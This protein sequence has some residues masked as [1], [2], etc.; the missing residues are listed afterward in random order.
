[1]TTQTTASQLSLA[2][3]Q[4]G[5]PTPSPHFLTTLLSS[6]RIAPP[7]PALLA[8][9]RLRLL[10]SDISSSPS[11]LAPTTPYFPPNLSNPAV[12]ELK[13]SGGI[14][15]QVLGVEDLSK[16]RWEQVEL[17]EAQERGETTRGREII[18]VVEPE[19]GEDPSAPG[20][21]RHAGQAGGAGGT[22]RLVLQDVKGQKVYGLE[23]KAVKGIGIGMS[24]GAKM[25]LN[26]ATVARGVVLLEPG[27][28]VMLGG[29]IEVL[30]KAWMENRKRDLDAAIVQVV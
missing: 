19:E 23:L 26:G 4:S 10:S 24:I 25:V 22:H 12:R 16:S 1:M 30:H 3:T 27:T 21:A 5:L 8:T 18:R 6:Q 15:V 2:L 13:L 7:L 14:P 20:S 17:I 29:K 28:V 11:P 9:A